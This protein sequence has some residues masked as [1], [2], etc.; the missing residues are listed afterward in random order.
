MRRIAPKRQSTPEIPTASTADIAFLLIIFFMVSTHFRAEQGLKINLP[1]AEMTERIVKKR[2][3]AS[4]WI[5]RT[6]R[7][8]V[9]DNWVSLPAVTA[10]MAERVIDNPDLVVI[11]Q[12]DRDVKYGFITDVLE[13]LKEG[14]AFKVT[15]ATGYQVGGKR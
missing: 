10:L 15:F 12:A 11:L 4:V 1:A 3:V 13:A 5:D 14:R 9:N 8:A 6:G 7:T 2:N